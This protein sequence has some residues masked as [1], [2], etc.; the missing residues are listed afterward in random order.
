MKKF[1][2]LASMC[3]VMSVSAIAQDKPA[4]REMA[5]RQRP[6]QEQMQQRQRRSMDV[7]IDTAV[8]NSLNLEAEVMEKVTALKEAKQVEQREAMKEMRATRGQQMGEEERKA[9][10]EK[11]QAFTA[12]YRKELRT[13]LGDE[14]Y[15]TYLEKML[16]RQNMRMGGGM[17]PGQGPRVG[18]HQGEFNRGDFSG[19][20]HEG[21]AAP[22]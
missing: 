3:L 14:A 4:K 15:I 1:L 19:N 21:M 5:P 7:V 9:M 20:A 16:D 11:M 10:R 17:R 18:Q 22:F 6:Q 12:Q 13:I 2:I 8:I